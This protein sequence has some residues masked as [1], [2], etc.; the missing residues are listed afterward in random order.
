MANPNKPDQPKGVQSSQP[1]SDEVY[2]FK[3]ADA[4]HKECPWE[5]KGS[6]PDEVLRHVE[7]HGREQHH[8]TMDDNAR[9][10]I[11]SKIQRAA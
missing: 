3:C 7:Q 6:S 9:S 1:R 8:L 2:R 4:G 10:Q 11:R 5:T